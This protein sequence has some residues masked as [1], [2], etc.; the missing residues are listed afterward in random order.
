MLIL[1]KVGP[2]GHPV[3]LTLLTHLV[4]KQVGVEED[5]DSSWGLL[6]CKGPS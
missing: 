4:D 1:D 6:S 3:G 5:W 2:S